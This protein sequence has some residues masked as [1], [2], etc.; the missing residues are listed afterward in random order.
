MIK[1]KDILNECPDVRVTVTASDLKEFARYV[2]DEYAGARKAEAEERPL[3]REE[4]CERWHITK[5][6][7]HSWMGRGLV[8]PVRI[9]GRTL[10]PMGEITRAEAGGVGKSRR[11]AWK[12]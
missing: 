12:K 4:L 7:L 5:S 6:T 9:G 8:R 1:I 11:M 10:F 3:G 2:I